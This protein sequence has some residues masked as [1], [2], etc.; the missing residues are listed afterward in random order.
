MILLIDGGLP[1][2]TTLM[3]HPLAT[4]RQRR[5]EN[6]SVYVPMNVSASEDAFEITA[7]VPGIKAEDLDIQVLEDRIIIEGEFT[8][9]P[10]D[11]GMRI[12]RQEMPLGQFQRSLRL[13]SKLD[14]TKAEAVVKDGILTLSVPK[15]EEA[16]THKIAVKA[17]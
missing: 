12:L 2:M 17:K 9:L 14:S 15:A 4:R 8:D 13:R 6:E 7:F 1:I 5:F 10:E 16:K 3:Y 11:D